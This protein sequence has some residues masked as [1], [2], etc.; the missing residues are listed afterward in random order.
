MGR[1][2]V[3]SKIAKGRGHAPM[4]AALCDLT[5]QKVSGALCSEAMAV[6][7][8]LTVPS[9]G[10]SVASMRSP[11]LAVALLIAL[12]PVS[13][14]E[15][16]PP[17]KVPVD[18]IVKNTEAKL[19]Q[20]PG[21]N[22]LRYQLARVHYLT[23]AIKRDA[24]GAYERNEQE[25]TAERV[26]D[27][28]LQKW[29]PEKGREISQ[30]EA[31]AH[32]AKA[33][34]LF[35]EVIRKDGRH[36]LAHLGMGSLLEQFADEQAKTPVKEIPA[37]LAKHDGATIRS[38]YAK[39]FYQAWKGEITRIEKG[40]FGL[41]DFVSYE[42]AQSYLRSA[43]ADADT[44]TDEEKGDIHW[45]EIAMKKMEALPMG[46]ITPLVF[47]M[48]AAPSID[49]LLAPGAVVEFDLR[50]FGAKEFWP[51][52]RADSGV[53][54]WDPKGSGHITSARQ[55]FG[56]YSWQ[57]FWHNGFEAL[58]A[59]DDNGDGWLRGGELAGISVWFDR[60]QDAMSD[61]GEVTPLSAL[62]ITGLVC[63]ESEYEGLHPMNRHGIELREGQTLPLW[64]W[65]VS[66]IATSSTTNSIA[67]RR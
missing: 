42:A 37:A 19:A 32:A 63:T 46:P 25:T 26:A 4:L 52:L 55:M 1:E 10:W 48:H 58:A 67:H 60:N 50:G 62:G 27:K 7:W 30:A 34:E 59:L 8:N 54:V 41:A 21:D 12:S 3:V 29:T 40:P 23:F 35:Q 17:E 44:L 16:A 57:L 39:A 22:E 28:R 5:R 65:I 18:R 64:D 9:A 43:K 6:F 56:S 24:L 66:P 13:Q 15:F 51:W 53:L 61:P 20:N 2:G 14:A 47:S 49:A 45:M 33:A 11:L 36:A 38:C 31:V